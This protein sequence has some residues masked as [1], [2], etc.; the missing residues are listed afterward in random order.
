METRVAEDRF[1]RTTLEIRVAYLTNYNYSLF[2]KIS[3]KYIQSPQEVD[4]Y[5]RYLPI[6]VFSLRRL[7]I[8]PRR[9]LHFVVFIMRAKVQTDFMG[10]DWKQ[11]SANESA[12]LGMFQWLVD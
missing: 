1:G 10:V 7:C 2:L 8:I 9:R 3:I 4:L 11:G 6:V 12:A 5:T